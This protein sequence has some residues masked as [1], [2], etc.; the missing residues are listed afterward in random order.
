MSTFEAVSLAML[1]GLIMTVGAA[2]FAYEW[3]TN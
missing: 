2:W 1:L 3:V